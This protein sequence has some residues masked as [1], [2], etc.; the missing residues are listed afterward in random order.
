MLLK[1]VGDDRD[2]RPTDLA[3]FDG[4]RDPIAPLEHDRILL[5]QQSLGCT[6]VLHPIG[7]VFPSCARLVFYSVSLGLVVG[8]RRVLVAAK[9]EWRDA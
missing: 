4:K 6:S 5:L 2:V 1:A 7:T 9:G 3:W 8:L